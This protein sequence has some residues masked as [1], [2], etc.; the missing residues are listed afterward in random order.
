MKKQ[1]IFMCSLCFIFLT[2]GTAGAVS[3]TQELLFSPQLITGSGFTYVHNLNKSG[4]DSSD[5]NIE[6]ASLNIVIAD[7]GDSFV[8]FHDLIEIKFNDQLVYSK[9]TELSS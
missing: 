7:D 4:F 6:S 1:F 8:P 9:F 5:F 3:F 2:A